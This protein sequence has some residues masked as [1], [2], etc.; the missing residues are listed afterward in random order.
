MGKSRETVVDGLEESSEYFLQDEKST[1]TKKQSA[2]EK[3]HAISCNLI[4]QEKLRS[5]KKVIDI[6]C[7]FIANPVTCR[8]HYAM[9]ISQQTLRKERSLSVYFMTYFVVILIK[10]FT[11]HASTSL[12]IICDKTSGKKRLSLSKIIFL[13]VET[14]FRHIF[15]SGELQCLS[16]GDLRNLCANTRILLLATHPL[17]MLRTERLSIFSLVIFG[18]AQ[19]V[20]AL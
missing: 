18:E 1:S 4:K 6:S 15:P 16:H 3:S 20:C 7:R 14:T 9:T 8:D 11:S 5:A 2:I 13:V 10:N 17:M 19:V 12:L